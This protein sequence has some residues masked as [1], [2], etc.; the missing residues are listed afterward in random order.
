MSGWFKVV[1]QL[2]DFFV[3]AMVAYAMTEEGQR[4]WDDVQ[5][6]WEEAAN[7]E[8]SAVAYDFSGAS[9]AVDAAQQ[10]KKVAGAANKRIFG[11]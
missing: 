3:K 2:F 5:R 11:T 7:N 9:Q 4:E 1:F 6:S 8:G 10:E